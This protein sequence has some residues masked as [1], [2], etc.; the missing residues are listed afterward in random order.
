MVPLL[1]RVCASFVSKASITIIGLPATAYRL[2]QATAHSKPH[3]RLTICFSITQVMSLF[4]PIL[5]P[6]SLYHAATA[7]IKKGFQDRQF[8][9]LCVKRLTVL[10]PKFKLKAKWLA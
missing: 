8:L 1:M 9:N 2:K 3:I 6:Q 10:V 4:H 5:M 7:A